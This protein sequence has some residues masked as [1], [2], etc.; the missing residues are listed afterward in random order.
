MQLYKAHFKLAETTTTVR[1]AAAE[2]AASEPRTATDHADG[3]VGPSEEAAN[4]LEAATHAVQKM[5][6]Y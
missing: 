4:P 1:V 6:L 5:K 2:R 3:A